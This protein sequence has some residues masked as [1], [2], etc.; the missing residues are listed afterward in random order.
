MEVGANLSENTNNPSEEA[1]QDLFR[2][3]YSNVVRRV[4]VIVKEPSIAEDIAQDV[5]VKLYHADRKT[6]DNL[7]G[8]LA[9]VAVHT[10]YNHIRTEKRHHDRNNRQA[11]PEHDQ[12]GSIEDRYM[13]LEDIQEV[14]Q[15]LMKLPERD[16]DIL[17]M[18]FSGYSYE[19]IAQSKGLEKTSVGTLLAR[20]KKRFKQRYTEGGEKLDDLP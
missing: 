18:K 4:M 10:A 8:W 16:R 12:T 3:H 20:A 14:Q 1:F 9:M 19:E 7:P 15:A 17:M 2:Q 5:F 13:E 6:I 11:V